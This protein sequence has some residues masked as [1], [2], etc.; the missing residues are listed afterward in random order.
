MALLRRWAGS[1][2]VVGSALL[3]RGS[4]GRTVVEAGHPGG[5]VGERPE[6]AERAGDLADEAQLDVGAGE[7]PREDIV[8]AVQSLLD[9]A[10]VIGDLGIDALLQRCAGL[11]EPI[12]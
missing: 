6:P 2:Q 11:T 9:M 7:A 1:G 10:E 8:V 4:E 12:T 5:D 3:D